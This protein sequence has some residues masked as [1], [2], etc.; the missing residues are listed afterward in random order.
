MQVVPYGHPLNPMGNYKF[1][2]RG[3]GAIR[4]HGT[5]A[6]SY[7]YGEVETLGCVRLMNGSPGID[8]LV[9]LLGPTAIAEGI[10]VVFF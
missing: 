2:I 6:Y 4:I 5:A 7:N 8:Q 1:A 3:F 10:D 9:S